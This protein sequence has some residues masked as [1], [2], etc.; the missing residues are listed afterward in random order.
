M[1]TTSSHFCGRRFFQPPA[2]EWS[3]LPLLLANS[4]WSI[5]IRGSVATLSGV[6]R[7]S[8]MMVNHFKW[9]YIEPFK[10]IF[11]AIRWGNSF[12]C[13]SFHGYRFATKVCL[14]D[15]SI[16]LL[17]LPLNLDESKT[18]YDWILIRMVQ[19]PMLWSQEPHRV[20]LVFKLSIDGSIVKYVDVADT[21]PRLNIKTVLS[22]YGD[23]HVKDKTVVRTS[24]L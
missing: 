18:K 3:E 5:S 17:P 22:T 4:N 8:C 14:C 20:Y 2:P 12:L 16:S 1:L 23:F 24:Y 6:L 15:D 10:W 19:S 13:I 7:Y 11:L 21:G 9:R